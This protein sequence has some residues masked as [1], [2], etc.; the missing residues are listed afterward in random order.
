MSV[1]P[2]PHQETNKDLR[3]AVR[4]LCAKYDEEYWELADREHRYPEEFFSD[5]A[6]AGFLGI[7]I[8]EEYG[9]GGGTMSDQV[10]VMEE[11]AAGGGAINA[12]SSV[13]IPMLCVPT[14]L[15]FGTEKQRRA[16]LPRVASGELFVTFGVTEP[17]A[18]TDTTR[19]T[20]RATP[21]DDGWVVNG[22]KVWNSGAQRG[23][24][25]LL[26]ARTSDPG[27]GDKRGHG[28]TL[29]L[30][31]LQADTVDIRAIPKIGRNAVSSTEVFFRDHPV[32]TADVVGDVGKGFYHLL[33]SLNGERLLISAEALGLGRWAVE[34][35][36]RYA[37]ERV[38][39]DRQIGMNQGVQHPL[40]A[41]YLAL[42]AAGEVV[43]R[44]VQEY[45]E[46]GGAAVG[47]LANAAKYLSSEAAF[48]AADNA[49]QV[50]G[51]YAYAR[52]YHIGRYWIESRLQR[53]A[54]VNNQMILNF[55]AE[56]SLGLP[57]SY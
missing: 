35:G 33:H 8:P 15:A 25:I 47:T 46:K 26:L 29:F 22:A 37:N 6:A 2:F 3:A 39:F 53:I 49:M 19:I 50:F 32:S 27:P 20:T 12:C 21:T 5:F 17:D 9:G 14:V 30:A 10:A 57:R 42:L 41:S 55:I 38:V 48:S 31:D 34:A 45:E 44:A 52:E 16:I 23:D 28:L 13:H 4:A 11:L 18:G 40:A 56:R 36:A 43:Y 7:L 54:P 1:V 51:G 24:K